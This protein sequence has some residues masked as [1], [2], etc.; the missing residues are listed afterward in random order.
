[1]SKTMNFEIINAN[2]QQQH[3]HTDGLHP[4]ITSG[5][6]LIEKSIYNLVL[7]TNRQNIACRLESEKWNIYKTVAMN[8]KKVIELME[9][10]VED[11]GNNL[12]IMRP[13]PSGLAERPALLDFTDYPEIFDE[14]L[15]EA[16]P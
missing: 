10:I 11:N 12:P 8:K 14:W 2:L 15:P 13:L 3:M 7:K 4:S 9:T 6:I 5:R 1:M 16:T